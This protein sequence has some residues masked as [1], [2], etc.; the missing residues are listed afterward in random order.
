MKEIIRKTVLAA[1]LLSTLTFA[2]CSDDD[3]AQTLTLA[4]LTGSYAGTFDFMPSPS[5]LN[6]DPKP[7]QGVAVDLKVEDGKVVIPEFPAATLIKALVGEE[8]AAGLVSM[9]G[10]IS[11][12][13]AIGTPAADDA[14]LT[15]K[16]TTPVLRLD[17]GGVLVV[18]IAI[19]SPDDLRYTKNGTLTFTLKTTQCQLGEGEEAGAPFGLVNELKFTVAKK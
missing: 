14:A 2:A 8:S 19:E 1:A 17:V 4:D 16:L 13:A 5:D 7:E 3:D 9:L 15:A 18:L 6:P 10:A 12:E 11:Y